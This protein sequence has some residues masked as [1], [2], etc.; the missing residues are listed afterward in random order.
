LISLDV[1]DT[2]IIM[3]TIVIVVVL[4]LLLGGGG[5]GFSPSWPLSL[6]SG[7]SYHRGKLNGPMRTAALGTSGWIRPP[8][9]SAPRRSL[10]F[11]E[12]KHATGSLRATR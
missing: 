3:S 8:A 6:H 1:G 9:L 7:A 5:W 4:V 11:V 2:T 10:G 12:S